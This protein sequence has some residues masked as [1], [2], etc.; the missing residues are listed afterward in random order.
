L[1]TGT[2][3][4]FLTAAFVII[5]IPGPTNLMIISTS[6]GAGMRCSFWTVLGA[7]LSHAVFIGI[8]TTGVGAILALDPHIFIFIKCFGVLYLAVQGIRLI[9]KQNGPT[10]IPAKG[11][12]GNSVPG[13]LFKGFTVNST[14]PKALLFYAAHFPHL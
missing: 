10:R 2:Y 3:L 6:I 13:C 7:A 5:V 11:S 12:T 4:A 1:E 8:A 14:N 9:V